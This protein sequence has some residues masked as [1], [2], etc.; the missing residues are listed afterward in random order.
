MKNRGLDVVKY[1]FT[2]T[3]GFVKMLGVEQGDR[4]EVGKGGIY[5]A[6]TRD[7]IF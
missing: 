4:I 5:A 3:D 1:Y 6:Q 2:K 7:I